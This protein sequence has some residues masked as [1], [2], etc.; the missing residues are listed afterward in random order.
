MIDSTHTYIVYDTNTYKINSTFPYYTKGI[1]QLLLNHPTSLAYVNVTHPIH[2]Q[3]LQKINEA[4]DT[5]YGK[6]S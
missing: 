1:S 6:Q 2:K 3:T 4:N 5:S